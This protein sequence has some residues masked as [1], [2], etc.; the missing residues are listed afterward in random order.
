MRTV[1]LEPQCP[2]HGAL[3]SHLKVVTGST[4]MAK[5][6]D[7]YTWKSPSCRFGFAKWSC[8]F[9]PGVTPCDALS[10]SPAGMVG[11]SP[12]AGSGRCA[13]SQLRHATEHGLQHSNG[14]W[15]GV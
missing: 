15:G 1:W 6:E 11:A 2:Q 12:K 4:Y 13:R 14:T 3:T 9:A 8:H 10:T 7:G 5:C